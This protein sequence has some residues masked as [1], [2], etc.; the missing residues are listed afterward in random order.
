MK[1]NIYR[2]LIVFISVALSLQSFSQTFVE[3]KN[4]TFGAQ[5]TE[6]TILEIDNQ[7][8]DI[9]FNTWEKDS[10]KINVYIRIE[11]KKKEN[12]TKASEALNFSFD[13]SKTL[14]RCATKYTKDAMSLGYRA[15]KVTTSYKHIVINYEVFLPQSIELDVKNRFG[16]I[17]M[18][19]H[20]GELKVNISHGTLRARNLTSVKKIEVKYGKLKVANIG[21][22]NIKLYG[23]KSAEIKKANELSLISTSSDIEIDHVEELDLTSKHDEISIEEIST[24]KGSTSLTDMKIDELSKKL[25]L[26]TKLGSIKIKSIEKT[27]SDID[28]YGNRTDVSLSFDEENA[29]KIIL[30]TDD[31]KYMSYGVSFSEIETI[32]MEKDKLR[33]T[34]SLG[35]GNAKSSVRLHIT[36]AYID[37]SLN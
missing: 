1:K 20:D 31:K 37:L 15:S 29:S 25:I 21:D 27:I 22:A 3:E 17:Y 32:K 30:E 10:V 12:M 19:N 24:C 26:E 4:K 6:E 34:L 8:G 14:V 35:E 11:S 18:E 2:K 36:N 16:N 7:Y 28:I 13:K 23:V 9:E 5:V 33:T